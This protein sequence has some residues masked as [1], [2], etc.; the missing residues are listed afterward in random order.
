MSLVFQDSPAEQARVMTIL[1]PQP[2]LRYYS[3]KS[4]STCVSF[5]PRFWIFVKRFGK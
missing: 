3:L 1:P 5:I 2:K 4:V